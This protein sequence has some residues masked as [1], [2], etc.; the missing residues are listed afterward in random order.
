MNLD[1]LSSNIYALIK[2]IFSYKKKKL[3][4]F[5]LPSNIFHSIERNKI[6]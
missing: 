1:F 6:D 5:F 2:I 3:C 4:N